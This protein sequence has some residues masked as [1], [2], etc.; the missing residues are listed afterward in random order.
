MRNW[1]LFAVLLV[2]VLTGASAGTVEE[3]RA[4][5]N[6]VKAGIDVYYLTEV[7][8]NR[9]YL[10]FPATGNYQETIRFYW[11]SEGGFNRLVL[12]T[13]SSEW[14]AHTEYGEVLYRVDEVCEGDPEEVAFQFVSSDNYGDYGTEVR[15][16]YDGEGL[17]EA[18]G[19]SRSPDGEER[20][21]P[22]AGEERSYGHN[23]EELLEMFIS[24]HG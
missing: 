9:D 3:V 21:V 15:W 14:A 16:Y 23:H 2:P 4:Y 13:W 18:S 10:M 8:V 11:R 17:F 12:A 19:V 1:P 7:V 6:E 22:D 24:I 5:Y 20:Y